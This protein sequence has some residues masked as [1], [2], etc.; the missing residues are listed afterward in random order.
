[1]PSEDIKYGI[2]RLDSVLVCLLHNLSN[3]YHRYKESLES[4]FNIVL[5]ADMNSQAIS[6]TD[7]AYSLLYNYLVRC[8]LISDLFGKEEAI[9]HE[10]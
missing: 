7:E 1:M 8:C 2:S 10:A 6:Y 5:Q 4:A 3:I 9:L